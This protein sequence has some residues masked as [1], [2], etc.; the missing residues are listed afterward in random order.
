MR[1]RNKIN[2]STTFLFVVLFIMMNL[3]IYYLFNNLLINSET[4]QAKEE[5][6]RITQGINESIGIIPNEQLLRA[7]VPINGMLRVVT[8]DLQSLP[9]ITSPSEGSLIK[10]KVHYYSE[11]KSETIQYE[12]KTY[13]F[14]SVPFIWTN[15]E[16]ANLQVT[17]SIQSTIDILNI[18]RL[19][20]TSVTIIAMVPV[21]IS[22]RILSKLITDPIS[23]MISTMKEIRKSGHFKRIPLNQKSTK[24]E[25]YIMGETFNHMMDLLETNF[26]KQ[27]QFISNAS[28]ELRTP[29]TIIESYASLLKRRGL[30]EPE[31]FYESIETIHSEAIRMKEMTEQLFVLAKN[32]EE[33]NINKETIYLAEHVRETVQAFE[34]AFNRTITLD[35]QDESMEV[36]ADVQKLKQLTYIILDN[37]NKYSEE[38]IH[39]VVGKKSNRAYI[40]II[41]RGIGIPKEELNKVF[42]RFYRVDKARSRKFG[43][44]GLGLSLAKEIAE[45]MDAEIMMNSIEGMGTT[46]TIELSTT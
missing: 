44:T 32:N 35:I 7:Y 15:G 19:V 40:Q 30:N 33:W 12:G 10:Q 27:D 18:L 37:A 42:D 45:A 28:H 16:V 31:L 46:V 20:L 17:N 43:G 23:S 8:E 39:V 41:D 21:V 1:L 6:E 14:T 9:S 4:E 34:K 29:L 24:D 25:L 22:S 13:T 3:S 38:T 26:E 2:F 11:E 5:A 36:F